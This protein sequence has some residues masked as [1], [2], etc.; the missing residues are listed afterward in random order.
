M[1]NLSSI[2]YKSEVFLYSIYN[3]LYCIYNALYSIYNALYSIYN[4]LYSIYDALYSIYNA[5]AI[6][7]AKE[8]L[9]QCKFSQVLHQSFFKVNWQISQWKPH[10]L[11]PK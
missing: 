11:S 10:L 9:H 8:I 4:A 3:A 5:L 6:E 2:S 7:T 1:R